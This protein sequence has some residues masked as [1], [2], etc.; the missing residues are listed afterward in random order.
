MGDRL[1]IQVKLIPYKQHYYFFE[2]RVSYILNLS[3]QGWNN[4]ISWWTQ[5]GLLLN[6]VYY[7]SDCSGNYNVNQL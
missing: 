1:L 6:I 4:S 7:T 5:L 2:L 3:F